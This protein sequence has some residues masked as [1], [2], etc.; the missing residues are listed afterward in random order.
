MAGSFLF[1]SN[2]GGL[3]FKFLFITVSGVEEDTEN[4]RCLSC[5]SVC[6]SI[7]QTRCKH[8]HKLIYSFC[9]ENPRK[10]GD[11][12]SYRIQRRGK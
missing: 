5:H 2:V 6:I 1:S 3:I 12:K 7:T 10:V 9:V 8:T 11:R 4:I